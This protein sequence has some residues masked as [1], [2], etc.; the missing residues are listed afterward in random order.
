[1]HNNCYI[2]TPSLSAEAERQYMASWVARFDRLYPCKNG[3]VFVLVDSELTVSD[4]VHPYGGIVFN[5][6]M[7]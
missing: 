5:K 3:Q 4:R 6:A 7:P 1:M 2:L